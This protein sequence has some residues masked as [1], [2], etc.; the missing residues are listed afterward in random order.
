[1]TTRFTNGNEFL[2]A[3][4]AQTAEKMSYYRPQKSAHRYQVKAEGDY[5]IVLHTKIDG[6]ATPVDPQHAHVVWLNDGKELLN[7]ESVNKR[8][9][10]A[11]MYKWLD[12]RFTANMY[13]D[14][15]VYDLVTATG[16]Q[17]ENGA[18]TFFIANNAPEKM[19]D[20]VT[21]H[22]LVIRL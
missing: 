4:G 5:R 22:F 3:D 14:K 20:K 19:T 6:E 15:L 17:D 21:E 9:A 10:E 13:W 18:V 16:P 7:K 8:L 12:E 1:M 11:S 2:T